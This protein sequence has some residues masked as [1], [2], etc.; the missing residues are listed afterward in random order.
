MYKRKYE[1]IF[2]GFFPPIIVTGMILFIGL[3][4][5]Q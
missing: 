5:S 1:A 3:M 4:A 2:P